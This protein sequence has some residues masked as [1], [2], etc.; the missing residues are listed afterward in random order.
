M[1]RFDEAI[2]FSP[3][4]KSNLLVSL[5]VKTCDSEFL[6]FWVHKYSIYFYTLMDLFMLF[7]IFLVICLLISFNKLSE[8]LPA[9]TSA[10]DTGSL[11]SIYFG[12]NIL[13]P[14]P[15][16]ALYFA[17]DIIEE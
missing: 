11:W 10:R 7:Y 2:V 9:F 16:V 12:V 1:L 5:S 15:S 8:L 3:I 4:L 6:L 14:V 17:S 13:S